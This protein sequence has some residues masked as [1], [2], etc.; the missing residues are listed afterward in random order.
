MTN[1][2]IRI[3]G[4]YKDDHIDWVSDISKE[5]I[6]GFYGAFSGLPEADP[7]EYRVTIFPRRGGQNIFSKCVCAQDK[8]AIIEYITE[9]EDH[10][11]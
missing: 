5:Q 9:G 2:K 10:A 1:N 11:I 6:E 3:R 8:D 7:C 4:G